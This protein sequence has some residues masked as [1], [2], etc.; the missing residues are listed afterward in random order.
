MAAKQLASIS[1]LSPFL[2]FFYCTAI[3]E[4]CAHGTTGNA[5]VSW[6]LMSSAKPLTLVC[7]YSQ[8]LPIILRV[9]MHLN[10][11]CALFCNEQHLE[12]VYLMN[13]E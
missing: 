8:G 9:T 3:F 13:T 11:D 2:N 6:K 7:M 4:L 12:L 5:D 1:S 10:S